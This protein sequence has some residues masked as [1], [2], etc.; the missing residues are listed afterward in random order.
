LIC[1][2]LGD[3]AVLDAISR[4]LY[5]KQKRTSEGGVVAAETTRINTGASQ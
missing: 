5:R 2:P 1:L 3:N 4:R